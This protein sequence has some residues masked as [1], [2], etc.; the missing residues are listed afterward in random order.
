MR[1]KHRA[2]EVLELGP[3]GL[4]LRQFALDTENRF[5]KDNEVVGLAKSA[6]A[7]QGVP[8][9]LPGVAMHSKGLP[10][11]LPDSALVSYSIPLCVVSCPDSRDTLRPGTRFCL[12]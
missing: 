4:A 8:E 10:K 3:A 1:R 5:A 12:H 2:V 11:K 9:P 7:I 6:A